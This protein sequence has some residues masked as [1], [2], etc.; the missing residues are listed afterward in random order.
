MKEESSAVGPTSLFTSERVGVAVVAP[1]TVC[2][3]C[4]G[5]SG[6]LATEM[7]RGTLL[8][9]VWSGVV[10]T[11][12]AGLWVRVAGDLTEDRSSEFGRLFRDSGRFSSSVGECE[13][14][15]EVRG[16]GEEGGASV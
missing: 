12:W 4:P 8:W 14:G 9:G 15:R 7:S 11:L 13:G 5:S 6:E 2:K 1:E 16:G 3:S 10:R